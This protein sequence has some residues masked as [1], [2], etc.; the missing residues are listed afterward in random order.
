MRRGPGWG[1]SIGPRLPQEDTSEVLAGTVQS[2]LIPRTQAKNRGIHSCNFSVVH[3][4]S[5]PAILVE[6]G[7]ISNVFEAQLLS[8]ES[9][10]ESLAQGIVEG[11]LT[12]QKMR[13]RP[14]GIVP[15]PHLALLAP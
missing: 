3:H 6:G 2:A 15:P 5:C 9:Y 12:Y 13:Q 4:T 1:F 14:G 11:V 10:R 7:F 8:N